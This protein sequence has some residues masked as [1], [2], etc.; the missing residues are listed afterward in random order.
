M[1]LTVTLAAEGKKPRPSS[2]FV[3][4]GGLVLP[5]G[6]WQEEGWQPRENVEMYLGYHLTPFSALE[7]GFHHFRIYPGAVKASYRPS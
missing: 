3:V 4:R 6:D 5:V 7:G 1:T 2:T